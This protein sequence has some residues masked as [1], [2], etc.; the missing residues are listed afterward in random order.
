MAPVAATRFAT[1]RHAKRFTSPAFCTLLSLNDPLG[2][3]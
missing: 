2:D 3:H 1:A